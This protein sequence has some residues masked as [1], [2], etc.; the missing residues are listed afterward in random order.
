MNFI[1][2]VENMKVS[3]LIYWLEDIQSEGYGGYVLWFSDQDEDYFTVDSVYCDEDGDCCLQS[4]ADS[5]YGDLTVDE[6]L[7]ELYE[8]GD[9]DYVYMEHVD[10]YGD[11]ESLWEHIEGGWYLDDDGD[12]VMDMT[13]ENCYDDD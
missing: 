12:L 10:E 8:F 3:R 5:Q 9:D 7:D 2:I 4:E 1:I 13:Y 11:Q 6:L